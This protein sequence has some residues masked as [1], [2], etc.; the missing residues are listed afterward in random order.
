MLLVLTGEWHILGES[1]HCDNYG[2][3]DL[4]ASSFL[5]LKLLL[6]V[7]IMKYPLDKSRGDNH[8]VLRALPWGVGS[9]PTAASVRSICTTPE[10]EGESG[11][12]SPCNLHMMQWQWT[13]L[14]L[15]LAQGRYFAT[16]GDAAV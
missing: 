1:S 8:F 16:S 2:Y 3:S 15:A 11:C 12:T 5:Q 14:D 10:E 9:L 7:R 13:G 4:D 6:F